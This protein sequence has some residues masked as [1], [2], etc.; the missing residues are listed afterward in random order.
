MEQPN[1]LLQVIG[2]YQKK[3]DA[4]SQIN[5]KKLKAEIRYNRLDI[6]GHCQIGYFILGGLLII[7][8]FIELLKPKKWLDTV[9]KILIGGIFLI[10]M[11]HIY[12]MGLRAYISGYAPWSNSYETMVYAGWATVLQVLPLV[13]SS[14]I[15]PALATPRRNH[16]FVSG[17]NWMD[18][19]INRGTRIEIALVNVSCGIIVAAYGFSASVFCSALPI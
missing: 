8:T 17:L 5:P 14:T 4:A 13:E 11:Y 18:P 3:N 7:F 9:V 19:Q 6:F 10:F 16:P 2:E 15:P 12:G 1:W